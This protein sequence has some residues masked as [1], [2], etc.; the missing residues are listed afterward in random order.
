MYNTGS[1]F[2]H[3]GSVGPGRIV[4]DV[5]T[6]IRD[7]LQCLLPINARYLAII[8]LQVVYSIDSIS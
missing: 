3:H 7:I 5:Y 6:M 1:A 4:T 2:P 8:N